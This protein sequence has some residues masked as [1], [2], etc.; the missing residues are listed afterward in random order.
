MSKLALVSY[1]ISDA[2]ERETR[3]K[4]ELIRAMLARCATLKAELQQLEPV[5]GEDWGQTLAKYTKFVAESRWDRFV[6]DYNRLYDELPGVE[7]QLE[8]AL[9]NARTKR[10]RLE[11]TAATL[12]AAGA[13]AEDRAVLDALSKG[14]SGLYADRFAEAMIKVDVML[15]QRLD[16]PLDVADAGLS[17]AQLEL[18]RDLLRSSPQ[19]NAPEMVVRPATQLAPYPE[20]ERIARLIEQIG[21]IDAT[22]VSLG[23]LTQRLHQL[24]T[25]ES[26]QRALLIDSIALEAK[27]RLDQARHKREVQRTVD[28]GLAWL[29]PFT[30]L[31]ADNHR[32]RLTAARAADDLTAAREAGTEARVWAEAEG[33][34][35]DGAKVRAALLNQLH[36]LGYQVNVQGPVWGEGTEVTLSKPNE[37]NY[38]IQLKAPPGGKVQSK[39]RAY[40]HGGRGPGINRRDVEVEQSWC[41]DLA[42]VNKAL[43]ER[44]IVGDIV[45]EDAPG[46]AAQVPLPARNERPTDITRLV[47]REL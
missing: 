18:A 6:D 9:A 5:A 39:V 44:G 35:A 7:R 20:M 3:R 27:E 19:D 30:S 28:E 32:A 43:A 46:T 17:A 23:D 34:R 21:S 26:G 13:T 29:S 2:D 8:M 24:P 45:H 47:E 12:A 40:S 4:I 14:A 38:D 37:P 41:S 15:R 1:R 25:R 31:S 33:K 36:E 10:M 11:L 22:L 42:N 16:T